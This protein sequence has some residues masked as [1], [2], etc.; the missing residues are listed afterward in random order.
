MQHQ[1]VGAGGGLLAVSLT[2]R[3]MAAYVLGGVALT[4]AALYF[5]RSRSGE[6]ESGGGGEEGGL[7]PHLKSDAELKGML[8]KGGKAVIY[9]TASW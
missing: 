7:M 9:L 4:G 8:D 5:L 1:Q 6:E 3:G 2:A